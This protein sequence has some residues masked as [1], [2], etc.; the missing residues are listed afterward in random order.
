MHIEASTMAR[1]LRKES[2]L[3]QGQPARRQESGLRSVCLI[4]GWVKILGVWGG[5]AGEQK[6]WQAGFPQRALNLDILGKV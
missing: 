3:L 1:A 5:Q 4:W 6:L 2:T